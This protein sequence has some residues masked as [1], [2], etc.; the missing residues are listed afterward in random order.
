MLSKYLLQTTLEMAKRVND[1]DAAILED[2]GVISANTFIPDKDVLSKATEE[3]SSFTSD[4]T[5]YSDGDVKIYH[6]ESPNGFK[7]ALFIKGDVPENLSMTLLEYI[8]QLCVLYECTDGRDTFAKELLN[9]TILSQNISAEYEKYGFNPLSKKGIA[10]IYMDA[11]EIDGMYHIFKKLWCTSEDRYICS[12]EDSLVIMGDAEEDEAFYRDVEFFLFAI[13]DEYACSYERVVNGRCSNNAEEL[14]LSY[15]E[16][17]AVGKCCKSLGLKKKYI[18]YDELGVELIISE[19]PKEICR[20]FLERTIDPKVFDF[21]DD[22][23]NTT[24]DCFFENSL[25]TSETAK[26]LYVHRN[27][28]IYRLNKISGITG[29]DI[30]KFEDAVGFKLAKL[31]YM[32][33]N[34]T[35]HWGDE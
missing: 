12:I 14:R 26:Q 24:I 4:M 3:F 5:D 25:N 29:L 20:L 28:L 11:S 34:K 32:R 13:E 2:G 10:I 15:R 31:I 7:R 16:A 1:I 6:I 19:T 23:L 27:T 9:N 22:E 21:L 30:K 33:L 35:G 18:S 17:K 8:K